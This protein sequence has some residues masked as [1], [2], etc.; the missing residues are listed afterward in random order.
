MGVIYNQFIT[1][2]PVCFLDCIGG[3]I[4][5]T[6]GTVGQEVEWIASVSPDSFFL[7][8]CVHG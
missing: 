7:S 2:V 4:L 8:C 3:L 6:G 5:S 1:L